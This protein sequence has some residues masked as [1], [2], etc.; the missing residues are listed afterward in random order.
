MC[1]ETDSVTVIKQCITITE[2]HLSQK[3]VNHIVSQTIIELTW[4][5]QVVKTIWAGN[6]KVKLV[7]VILKTV[8]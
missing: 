1:S 7:T 6:Q 4:C 2:L 3:A 8:L 5:G